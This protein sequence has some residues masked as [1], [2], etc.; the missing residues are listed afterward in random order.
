M[1]TFFIFL[2]ILKYI[3]QNY[4]AHHSWEQSS[5]EKTTGHLKF[6][7]SEEGEHVEARIRCLSLC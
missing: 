6:C 5:L 2:C 4:S 1:I 3:F 7:S